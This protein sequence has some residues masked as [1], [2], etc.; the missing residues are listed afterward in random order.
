M[1]KKVKQVSG[2]CI[3]LKQKE[4]KNSRQYA[5]VENHYAKYHTYM[6]SYTY[7]HT[8]QTPTFKSNRREKDGNRTYESSKVNMILNCYYYYIY[9]QHN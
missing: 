8:Q 4:I 9:I 6:L 3:K 1:Q 7:T 2:Q 5:I